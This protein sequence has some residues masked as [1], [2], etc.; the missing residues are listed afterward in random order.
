MVVKNSIA[1]F[2]DGDAEPV[3][4][5]PSLMVRPSELAFQCEEE[6]TES[7]TF[8]VSGA[9][10]QQDVMLTIE[11]DPVFSLSTTTLPVEDVDQK[12]A[13]VTV[14]FAPET[15][16]NYMATLT[17][18]SGGAESVVISLTGEAT[19]KIPEVPP[20]PTG[21]THHFSSLLLPP[22]EV[23]NL[24]GSRMNSSPSSINKGVFIV[25]GKKVLIK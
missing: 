12:E 10:L 16:G 1:Y 11:G 8:T 25:N 3:V 6:S 4:S 14:T 2:S 19:E 20:T 22:S 18:A 9:D 5:T 21:I 13:S 24:Q 7:Q 17:I 15:A 23:Y